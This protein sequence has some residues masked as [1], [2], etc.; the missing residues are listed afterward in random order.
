M[1]P[2]PSGEGW[3][4]GKFGNSYHDSATLKIDHSLSCVIPRCSAA[5]FRRWKISGYL[6]R[7]FGK[8]TIFVSFRQRF[9]LAGLEF[10]AL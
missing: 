3:G 8:F 2:L 7:K 4:E 5:I 9:R 6:N 10:S 1:F